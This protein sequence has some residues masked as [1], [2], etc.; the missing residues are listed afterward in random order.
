MCL[1]ACACLCVCMCVHT[2]ACMWRSEESLQ[3]I[4]LSFQCVG[5]CYW[6]QVSRFDK[7][8]YPLSHLTGPTEED[9]NSWHKRSEVSKDRQTSNNQ[10]VSLTFSRTRR[11]FTRIALSRSQKKNRKLNYKESST[12]AILKLREETGASVTLSHVSVVWFLMT[13]SKSKKH[14][15][16]IG[17]NKNR[18][19]QDWSQEPSLS[20]V[21]LDHKDILV[22]TKENWGKN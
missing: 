22:I 5:S 14:S 3:E 21:Y 20:D 19:G 2:V 1:C 6:S 16:F 13:L 9:F 12:K 4:G 10:R 7:C 11:I 17:P 8:L 18:H 15:Q